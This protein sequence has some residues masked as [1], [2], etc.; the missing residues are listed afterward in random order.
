ML[1]SVLCDE[2]Y[3]QTHSQPHALDTKDTSIRAIMLLQLSR[4]KPSVFMSL[5]AGRRR[6]QVRSLP[7][8]PSLQGWNERAASRLMITLLRTFFSSLAVISMSCRGRAGDAEKQNS[9]LKDNNMVD[10]SLSLSLAL[11]HAHISGYLLKNSPELLVLLAL[12]PRWS[13]RRLSRKRSMQR[14]M[15]SENN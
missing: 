11:S 10:N 3:V 8:N 2:V 1:L 6:T 9:H 7:A 12:F 14:K 13:R 4:L 15:W 5:S